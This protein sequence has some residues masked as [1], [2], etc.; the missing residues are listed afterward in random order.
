VSGESPENQESGGGLPSGF[1]SVT[2]KLPAVLAFA[3][4][5]GVLLVIVMSR[6]NA[7]APVLALA[8]VLAIGLSAHIWTIAKARSSAAGPLAS[9]VY[10]TG[11]V[12]DVVAELEKLH[13]GFGDQI[14]ARYLCVALEPLFNRDTFRVPAHLCRD[15]DWEARLR[16]ALQT[17]DVLEHYQ[18][19]VP[20]LV[21]AVKQYGVTMASILFDPDLRLNDVRPFRYNDIDQFRKNIRENLASRPIPFDRAVD[22]S[23]IIPADRRDVLEHD[24]LQV[25]Q[26]WEALGLEVPKDAVAVPVAGAS[27]P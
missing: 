8:F 26:A 6:T 18:R 16:A 13:R 27:E 12:D 4:L 7:L 9:K 21:G 22:G 17:L 25:R 11:R 20:T 23:P 5:I 14:R 19:A 3:V 1:Y 2:S 15:R 24:R 10:H